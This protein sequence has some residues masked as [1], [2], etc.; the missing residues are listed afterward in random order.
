MHHFSHQIV[1]NCETLSERKKR[2]QKELEQLE[3]QLQAATV[4]HTT[5]CNREAKQQ[6]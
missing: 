2:L 1:T 4:M 3:Q 5:E 6:L